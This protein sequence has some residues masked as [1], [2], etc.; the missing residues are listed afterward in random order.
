[1]D[2]IDDSSTATTLVRANFQGPPSRLRVFHCRNDISTWWIVNAF[3][4]EVRFRMTEAALP[5]GAQYSTKSG[6]SSF[7][8]GEGVG[9]ESALNES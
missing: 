1:M 3:L 8:D 6:E 4:P 5:V 7:D 9:F 2:T